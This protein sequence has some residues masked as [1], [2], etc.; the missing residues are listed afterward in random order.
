MGDYTILLWLLKLGAL[1]NV[2]FWVNTA[3]ANVDPYLIVP[4]RTFFAVCA[5]RCLF[6]VRYEHNVVF[7]DSA[8]SS[9]FATRALATFAE[10]AY[11][12]L[13]AYVLHVLNAEHVAW[14]TGAARLMVLQVVVCQACVWVAILTEQFAFYFYEELGWVVMYMANT[15]A[16]AYLYV[17][18]DALAGGASL[19]VLNVVFGV[20]YLPFEL[21]NLGA[22]RAQAK[23]EGAPAAPWTRE[24]FATGLR[25]SIQVKNPRTDA[26]SWGGLVGLIWMTGYWAT[27]LPLWV[28]YIVAVLSAR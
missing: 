24:R 16:S 13:L 1:A 17:T 25:R 19:L 2:Y 9:V 26:E 15:I 11:I 4:A 14:V 5:Y 27:V 23:R 10:I 22:V 21:I 3:A 20:V 8:L 12:F 6:P 18:V 28:Y 7:H